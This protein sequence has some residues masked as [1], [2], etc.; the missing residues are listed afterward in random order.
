MY[1]LY[2]QIRLSMGQKCGIAKKEVSQVSVVYGESWTRWEG[3]VYGPGQV[4]WWRCP[5]EGLVGGR[6]CKLPWMVHRT[7][8]VIKRYNSCMDACISSPCWQQ[9]VIKRYNRWSMFNERWNNILNILELWLKQCMV[10]VTG[11]VA[12]L[13]GYQYCEKR[14]WTENKGRGRL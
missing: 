7:S 2:R 6:I 12:R 11:G 9:P 3:E 5:R 13:T 1:R 10:Y 8:Q 14:S 4:G